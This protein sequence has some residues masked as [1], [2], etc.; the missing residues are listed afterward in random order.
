MRSY[1]QFC[2]VAQALEVVGERWTLL[3]VREL[4]SGSRRFSEIQ[5]GVPLMSPTLLSQRLARLER[6]G[7]VAQRPGPGGRPE[8]HP[9][10]AGR[11]L[12][13]VVEMLGTWGQ[14]WARREVTAEQLDPSLLMWDIRRRIDFTRVPPRRTVIRFAFSGLT[15]GH[16][17]W[18]LVLD[19]GEADLC[20]SDPGYDVDLAVDADLRS[21]I[22]VWMGD[23]PL[24]RVLRSGAVTVSGAR[25]LVR[26]FPGWLR[27]NL[28]A[29]VERPAPAAAAPGP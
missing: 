20:L 2:P 22:M 26:A 9:T 15:R 13:P 28:L 24:H 14:R 10:E 5:R 6:A 11:E 27:L 25:P 7:I 1:G 29:G 18:W 19:R 17:T 12:W 8:Y 16:R 4:L 21:L 3:V 23:L